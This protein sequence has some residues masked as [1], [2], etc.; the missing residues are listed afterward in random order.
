MYMYMEH[1]KSTLVARRE[2]IHLLAN[3]EGLSGPF[4]VKQTISGS[5]PVSWLRGFERHPILEM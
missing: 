4:S 1:H 5:L 3:A 2:A